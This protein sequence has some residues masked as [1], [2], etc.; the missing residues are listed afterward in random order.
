MIIFQTD[1]EHMFGDSWLYDVDPEDDACLCKPPDVEVCP[2]D[3]KE[4][5]EAIC[6][7]LLDPLGSFQVHLRL[8]LGLLSPM[9]VL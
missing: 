4:A 6:S 7:A 5:A 8:I 1:D 2:D 3:E 9:P